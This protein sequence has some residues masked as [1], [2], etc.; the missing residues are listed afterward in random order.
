MKKHFHI[1]FEVERTGPYERWAWYGNRASF[2]KSLAME[3][4]KIYHR[5]IFIKILFFEEIK[6]KKAA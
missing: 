3:F 2:L 1:K 6:H 5:K 4:E